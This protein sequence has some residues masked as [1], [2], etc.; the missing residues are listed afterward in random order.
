MA[1]AVQVKLLEAQT[2]AHFVQ[3]ALPEPILVT[4]LFTELI[5]EIAQQA[6]ARLGGGR[7]AQIEPVA[8]QQLALG[9]DRQVEP[10][11]RVKRRVELRERL[12]RL[13]V[14]PPR[15]ALSQFAPAPVGLAGEG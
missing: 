8:R 13:A 4:H 9:I 15:T 5:K 7:A 3:I 11:Q 12:P 2:L 6:F 10:L 1:Q 14:A